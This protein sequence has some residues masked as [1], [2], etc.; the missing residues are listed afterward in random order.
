MEFLKLDAD[1]V[2]VYPKK[3]LIWYECNQWKELKDVWMVTIF[4]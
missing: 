3:A 2:S 1:R 4:D